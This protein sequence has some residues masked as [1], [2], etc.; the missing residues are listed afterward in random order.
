MRPNCVYGA[1]CTSALCGVRHEAEEL[2]RAPGGKKL[3]KQ[4]LACCP[5][6]ED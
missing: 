5:A 2:A 3:G 4:W 6:H 1:I